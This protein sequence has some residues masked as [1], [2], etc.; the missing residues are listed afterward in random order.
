V[1][2]AAVRAGDGSNDRQ[3]EPRAFSGTCLVCATEAIEREWKERGRESAAL[4]EDVELDRAVTLDRA[5]ANVAISVTERVLDQVVECLLELPTVALECE[6]VCG[7][8][9]DRPPGGRCL[10]RMP[11]GNP[12]EEVVSGDRLGSSARG[13]A[14]PRRV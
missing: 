9:G 4:I 5:D 7:V 14:S 2:R 1:R 10:W 11:L 6:T 13:R 12:G 8:G 3:P